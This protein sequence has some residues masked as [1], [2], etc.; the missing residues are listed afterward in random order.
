VT[1]H[2]KV[3]VMPPS[4]K[5]DDDE[6]MDGSDNVTCGSDSSESFFR[7][8]EEWNFNIHRGPELVRVS[9]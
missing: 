7:N 1:T 3:T 5:M 6:D 2:T 8:D 9:I 4:K